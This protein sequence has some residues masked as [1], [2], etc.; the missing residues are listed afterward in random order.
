LERNV[1]QERIL[2]VD[3][4]E[5]ICEMLS[6]M[7]EKEGYF[8]QAV[9]TAKEALSLF[10]KEDFDCLILDIKMPEMDGLELLSQVKKIDSQIKVIMI[11]AF[12]SMESTIQALRAG[13]NDYF[14]KP[15]NGEEI[16]LRLK[17]LLER[18]R[19]ERENIYLRRRL[20]EKEEIK[21]IIGESKGIQDVLKMV[22]KVAKSDSTVMLYGESGT[23]KELIA[24][25]LHLKSNRG[26]GPF[27]SINCGALPETLLES[28]LFGHVKGSFTGAIKDKD[29]LFKIADGGTFLLD[30]VSETSPAI[31]I[32]LLRVLQEREIVP[33]GGTK[34]IKVD[35]RL[36]SATNAD[37]EKLVETGKFR[38]DL[39]YRLNVIPIRIP[40][41]RERR[42]DIPLLVDYFV[43]QCCK[44]MGKKLRGVS[45]EAMKILKA[46]DWP[47]N[48]REL[49]NTVERMVILEEEDLIEISAIPEKIKSGKAEINKGKER[50]EK[51]GTLQEMEKEK[52]IRTLAQ[53]NGNRVLAAQL[54]GIHPSTLYRKIERYKIGEEQQNNP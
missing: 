33:V 23:G 21:P 54:L 50:W 10:Q 4:E 24:R 19:L 16:K 14:V 32:K 26:N 30:E 7:L 52:I 5:S 42:E 28:E 41:L 1:S 51:E 44:R 6:I 53:T 40:P 18:D 3:D 9:N 29:G 34:S 2:I 36:I 43:K 12:G 37:L 35:V 8:T 49:E 39:F 25:E 31:Q 46:Y 11:T 22:E 13:A 38:A 27:V 48:V 15:F 45:S 20:S 47:G 17:N